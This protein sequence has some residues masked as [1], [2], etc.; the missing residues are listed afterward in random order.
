[1]YFK[2]LGQESNF[3][4]VI[5][6]KKDLNQTESTISFDFT[7]PEHNSIAIASALPFGTLAHHLKILELSLSKLFLRAIKELQIVGKC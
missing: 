4:D 1:M 2:T 7:L 6:W 3:P 5:E